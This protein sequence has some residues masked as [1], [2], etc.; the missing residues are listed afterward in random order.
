VSQITN[1]PDVVS[2]ARGMQLSQEDTAVINAHLQECGEC[3]DLVLFVRKTSA[4]LFQE[5]R[6]DRVAKA[7][8]MT[9]D[10]LKAEM[11]RGTSIAALI[12]RHPDSPVALPAPRPAKPLSPAKK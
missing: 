9:S 3:R 8:G 4:M 5:G 12:N 7:L 6:I 2:F 1:H 11:G 10:A